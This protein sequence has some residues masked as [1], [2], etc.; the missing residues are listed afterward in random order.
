MK[1][2]IRTVLFL[3]PLGAAALVGVGVA[4]RAPAQ[5]ASAQTHSQASAKAP[6]LKTPW[7]T[8]D[9]QGAWS[10]VAV[11]PF[12]RPK[13]FGNR[14]F[15]T[16]AEYKKALDDLLERDKRVGR[17]SRESNG[18]DIRGT[19]KDVARAY[20]EHWFGDKPTEVSRRTSMIIDP[21]DGRMP[22]FTPG[23]KERISEKQGYLD[24]LL[25]GTPSGKPGPISTRRSEPS[26]DYNLDRMNRADGPED[27]SYRERCLL[28]PV[29]VILP[30]GQL[31]A[32]G[33]PYGNF[34]GVMRIVE[35]PDSVDI[36]YDYGQGT[37]FNR[38]IP[39]S[40]RPHLPKEIRQYWGDPIA[41]WEGDTLV[42][43]V[44]NFSK[45]TNFHGSREN[46][47]L[48]ERYKRVDAKTLQITITAEDPTTWV[49]P[50]TFVEELQKNADKPNMVY[51]GGCH[52]GN[53]GLTG[54]LANMRAAEK[55]FSEG[56][57]PDPALED[58]ANGDGG[59][60]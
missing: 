52:E 50:F 12:E 41:H 2:R 20:N 38:P 3:A 7:G 23:A 42:V 4:T 10:T 31:T 45:E 6:T 40:N 27:R 48:I 8:P 22:A 58:N 43:D 44:T 39:I 30:P 60:N 56:K 9:L 57:G 1:M 36:Y 17:D 15:K 37:G 46:L 26:P 49:K 5:T 51:E 14:E 47:H 32:D 16:E 54:M 28:E 18:Q 25:Q 24:S 55:A 33:R 21:P 34:G 59:D 11:V 35:S 53:Y 19:A 13:E 29:P